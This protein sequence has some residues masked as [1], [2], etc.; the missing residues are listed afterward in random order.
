MAIMANMKVTA[1]ARI[2]RRQ[3]AALSGTPLLVT[4]TD[5]KNEFGRL[6]DAAIRGRRVLI[7]RHDTPR[8]VLLSKE[9]F[10]M[11]SG[12]PSVQLAALTAEFDALLDGL[13]T[14]KS[15]SALM[16]AFEA[17]PSEVGKAAVA[18]TRRRRRA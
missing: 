3:P 2:R 14:P 15:T 9:D 4:A 11:L 17:A 8:A 1:T 18:A 13:Q 12:A 16:M 10:D 6:L 7:T 5:A